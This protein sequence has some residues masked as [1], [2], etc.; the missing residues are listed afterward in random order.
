MSIVPAGQPSPLDRHWATL[1]SAKDPVYSADTTGTMVVRSNATL[2]V[3][4]T[5]RHE[6][7]VA[8]ATPLPRTT[9]TAHMTR[10]VRTVAMYAARR[11]FGAEAATWAARAA[12]AVSADLLDAAETALAA[13]AAQVAAS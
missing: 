8:D 4:Q 12:S 7:A 2:G 10:F 3:M 11:T 5:S 6:G 13:R 1:I 9:V